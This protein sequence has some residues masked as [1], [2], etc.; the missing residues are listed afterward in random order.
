VSGMHEAAAAYAGNPSAA[1]ATLERTIDR[2]AD[3]VA[4]RSAF[5]LQGEI[6]F[7]RALVALMQKGAPQGDLYGR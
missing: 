4:A 3:D 5:D 1:T 6:D 7:A 2:F